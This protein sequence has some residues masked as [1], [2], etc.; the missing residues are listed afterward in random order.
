MKL[1][2]IRLKLTDTDVIRRIGWHTVTASSEKDH[3]PFFDGN[4][5]DG[6]IERV[7]LGRGV[8]NGPRIVSEMAPEPGGLR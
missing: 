1:A 7:V 2:N 6:R 5:L 8:L 3:S 4:R